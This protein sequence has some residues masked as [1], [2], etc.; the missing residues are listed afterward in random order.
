M[1]ASSNI[2][3]MDC[4]TA[5]LA[6]AV[7]SADEVLDVYG[8]E[9]QINQIGDSLDEIILL[10]ERTQGDKSRFDE[11][12]R[13]MSQQLVSLRQQR[14]LQKEKMDAMPKVHIEIE[15]MR[16][17]FEEKQNF[18]S[19]RDDVV[20]CVVEC[21]RV[22]DGGKLTIILKGGYTVEETVI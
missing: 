9:Q 15:R 14:D 17:L 1:I 8:I 3:F 10:R 22:S 5:A 12:I 19:Y 4:I 11:E 21:I 6:Y 18:I 13:K 7:T 20:R 16:K 2:D